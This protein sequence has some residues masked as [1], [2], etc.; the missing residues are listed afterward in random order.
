MG[1]SHRPQMLA[2]EVRRIISDM[3]IRGELKDPAFHAMLGVSGVDVTNDGSYATVYITALSYTPGKEMTD[4]DRKK[5]LDAFGRCQG[6]I[7]STIGKRV[8]VR[9]VPE[10]I[11][12]FD[13]SFD[14]GRKMDKILDSIK[15]QE[16][17]ND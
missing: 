5:I 6:F 9:Y 12:K 16:E 17:K 14:Y 2:E 15:E 13:T 3:L 10:L 8:K 11:F 1:K 4:E 7:R